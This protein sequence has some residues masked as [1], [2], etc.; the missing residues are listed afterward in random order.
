LL[1]RIVWYLTLSGIGPTDGLLFVAAGLLAVRRHGVLA[2]L[3][4]IGG[5]AYMC[6]DSD[7]LWGSAI[8]DWP[9]IALYLIAI[10][11]LYLVVTPVALLRARTSLGRAAAVFVPVAAFHLSRLIVPGLVIQGRLSLPWGDSVLSANV[12]LSLMLAWVLYS[13]ID[14]SI[15]P[16]EAEDKITADPLPA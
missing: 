2:I 10:T 9:Y 5:Y 3:V 13:K 8:R 1:E 6:F 16:A 12:L 11:A 7:Y 15:H 14:H 4:V